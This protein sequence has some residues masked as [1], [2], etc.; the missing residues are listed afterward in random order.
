MGK[1]NVVKYFGN[2]YCL[3]FKCFFEKISKRKRFL[4]KLIKEVREIN[5]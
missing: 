1:V 2:V 3:L 5:K 4:I